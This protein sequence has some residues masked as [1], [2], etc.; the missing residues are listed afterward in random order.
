ML[1]LCYIL[2]MPKWCEICFTYFR[3]LKKRKRRLITLSC[4]HI[5]CLQCIRHH[6]K[7]SVEYSWSE[8][9]CPYPVPWCGEKITSKRCMTKKLFAILR[10]K[11]KM[12]TGK[13]NC[14]KKNCSGFIQTWPVEPPSTRKDSQNG[15][16]SCDQ[17]KAVICR[18]CEEVKYPGTNRTLRHYC[19]ANNKKSVVQK[20]NHPQCPRC[21]SHYEHTGGCSW[22]ECE[23]CGEGF[24][25]QDALDLVN[26]SKISDK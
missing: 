16:I 15:V 26:I 10:K 9:R 19:K 13:K 14:P 18:H 20:H 6:C 12:K 11:N 23:V 24:N 21:K 4:R 17:C 25:H 5:F 1:F 22:M 2:Q 3:E 8:P 7:Y